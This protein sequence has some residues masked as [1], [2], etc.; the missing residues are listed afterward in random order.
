MLTL[1]RRI[2]PLLM[3]VFVT[4]LIQTPLQAALITIDWNA[5]A[6]SDGA[7]S[8]TLG[9][10][11]VTLTSTDGT[12]NGGTTFGTTWSAN[13]ATDG[14]SGIGDAGVVNEAAGIDWLNAAS[15][16]A[17]VTFTGGSVLDPILLFNFTDPVVQTFDFDDGLTLSL[18]DQSPAASTTIAAGNII[19]TDGSATDTANDGFAVQLTGSFNSFTF[20]TNTTSGVANSVGFSVATSSTPEPSSLALMLVPTI[21]LLFRR[22]RDRNASTVS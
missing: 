17:T 20:L 6:T 16:S 13:S 1:R 19:T 22:R 5:D 14:V 7:A 3:G 10:R 4:L 21:G 15:G 8:G 11:T 2:I 12:L 9:A 18:L